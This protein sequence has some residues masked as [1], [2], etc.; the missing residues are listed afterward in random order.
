MTSRH[1]KDQREKEAFLQ[2]LREFRDETLLSQ[3]LDPARDTFAEAVER[4]YWEDVRGGLFDDYW[5][6]DFD[7][8]Y[9]DDHPDDDDWEPRGSIFDCRRDWD[10]DEPLRDMVKPGYHV[11]LDGQTY[12]VLEN[13]R[14]ANLLTGRVIMGHGWVEKESI[15]FGDE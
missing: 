15:V 1:W 11:R 4:Q 14:W 2:Q 5:E 13:G 3:D 8:L 10:E 12:L 9:C 7:A 6:V